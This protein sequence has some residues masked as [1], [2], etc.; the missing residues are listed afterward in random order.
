MHVVYMIR[1]LLRGGGV[2]YLWRN[3]VFLQK[4]KKL[5]RYEVTQSFTPPMLYKIE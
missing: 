1:E 4:I 5:L 2:E 3:S